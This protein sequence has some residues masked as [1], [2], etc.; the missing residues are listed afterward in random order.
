MT[1]VGYIRVSKK[2]Q[3]VALQRDALEKAGCGRFYEDHASGKDMERDGLEACLAEL[4]EGDT[5]V[6]WRLDR[7][8]RNVVNLYDLIGKF[9]HRGITF[10]SLMDNFDMTTVMGRAMFG[11]MAVFAQMEREM[12]GQRTK[13]GLEARRARGGKLGRPYD[14]TEEDMAAA[15]K[16][17]GEGL[18]Q[19]SIGNKLY[20]S[21]STVSRM[22]RLCG[23]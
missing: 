15:K 4:Q 8:G 12:I 5:L 10:V 18:S 2:E 13:A 21:Q 17:R 3:E 11:I 16:L 20:M 22:L 7:L 19:K 9:E 14:Y 23:Y 6:V 1:K